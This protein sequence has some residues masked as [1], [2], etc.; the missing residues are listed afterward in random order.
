L[1]FFEKTPPLAVLILAFFVYGVTWSYFQLSGIAL[2]SRL[3]SEQNR[4]SAL[5]MYNAIAGTGWIIAGIGS[6]LAAENGGYPLTFAIASGMLVLSLVVLLFVPDP[7]ADSAAKQ[8]EPVPS[9]A[10]TDLGA[11]EAS[12]SC[13]TD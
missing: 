8:T 3:A 13:T 7:T 12:A 5:G 10:A 1:A 9:A 4:G 6:G 2:T 11:A